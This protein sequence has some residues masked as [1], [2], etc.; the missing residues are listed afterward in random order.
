VGRRFSTKPIYGNEDIIQSLNEEKHHAW[1]AWP[2]EQSGL[3]L[4]V[5]KIDARLERGERLR[6]GW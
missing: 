2:E 6:A 3:V 4:H 1:L 5:S